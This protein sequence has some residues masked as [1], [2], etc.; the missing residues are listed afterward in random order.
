MGCLSPR[1]GKELTLTQL[2]RS[3]ERVLNSSLGFQTLALDTQFPSPVVPVATYL[4][5]M[6]LFSFASGDLQLSGSAHCTFST[7][8]KAIGKDNFTAIPEGTNGVEERMSVIWD[9]AVVRIKVT[10]RGP[11]PD[12]CLLLLLL[13]RWAL[14][15]AEMFLE[16][17]V[18]GGFGMFLLEWWILRF[19]GDLL[20]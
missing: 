17:G 8:Q 6:G 18:L 15:P 16:P 20:T 5:Y 11:G 14:T 7:A 13:C 12:Q 2:V 9:K 4:V 19:W 3:T 10:G 1:E